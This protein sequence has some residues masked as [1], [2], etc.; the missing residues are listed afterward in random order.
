MERVRVAPDSSLAE[1]R[2]ERVLEGSAGD[3]VLVGTSSGIQA[4]AEHDPY[5]EEDARYL[6]RLQ[7]QDH[8]FT[9]N[10]CLGTRR[11]GG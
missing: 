3:A 2:V 6:L 8:M 1:I 11:I 5:F 10:V 4:V 7:R 9:T